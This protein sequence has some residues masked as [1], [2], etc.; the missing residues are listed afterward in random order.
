MAYVS[1]FFICGV[2]CEQHSKLVLGMSF[3]LL[4]TYYYLLRTVRFDQFPYF[5]VY[6]NYL[7]IMHAQNDG[8]CKHIE[9]Y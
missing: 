8:K 4:I 5:A 6:A 2:P 1:Q 3:F 9:L 7:P